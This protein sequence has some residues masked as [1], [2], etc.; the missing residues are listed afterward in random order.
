MTAYSTLILA[1]TPTAY[2]HLNETSGTTCT[3]SSGNSRTATH[4]TSPTL[5]QTSANAALDDNKCIL[6]SGAANERTQINTDN[7]A[8]SMK[9]GWTLELWVNVVTSANKYI[10][11]KDSVPNHYEWGLRWDH[12]N[13]RFVWQTVSPTYTELYTVYG[14]S[15]KSSGTWYHVAVTCNGAPGSTLPKLYVNGVQETS[16]GS[17][18]SGGTYTDDNSLVE[19]GARP[20]GAT[21]INAKIDE[22]A[23]FDSALTSTVLLSHY[24]AGLGIA[25]IS[26]TAV[27][28]DVSVAGQ[29]AVI[30]TVVI[31][32]T[33]SNIAV[34]GQAPT[35]AITSNPTVNAVSSNIAIAGRD[36]GSVGTGFEGIAVVADVAIQ[37][38]PPSSLRLDQ[39]FTAQKS[40]IAIGGIN[41]S[42]DVPQVGRPMF[43]AADH[44]PTWGTGGWSSLNEAVPEDVYYD[45]TFYPGGYS[46]AADR[47]ARFRITPLG[48]PLAG[49]R[50]ISYRWKHPGALMTF[51]VILQ[52]GET[53]IQ[54]WN[55]GSATQ[56]SYVTTTQTITGT[57]TDYTN[58]NVI[59]SASHTLAAAGDS[60]YV[61]YA[62][63]FLPTIATVLDIT[64]NA[65]RTDTTVVGAAP[66][67]ARGVEVGL[68]TDIGVEGFGP[69]IITPGGVSLSIQAAEVTVTGKDP[70]LAVFRDS[71]QIAIPTHI[72]LG[73]TASSIQ[74]QVD[75]FKFIPITDNNLTAADANELTAINLGP[76]LFS[77][78]KIIAF[79]MG[80]IGSFPIN[81]TITTMSVNETLTSL[82]TFSA[83]K[84]AYTSTII[85]EG[86]PP[87]GISDPIWMKMN[88]GSTL[89]GA[90]TIVID[91]EQSNA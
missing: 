41:P 60:M 69:A 66:A 33:V 61:S 77:Q 1:S 49:P 26:Q 8:F 46:P 65:L 74:T 4:I 73:F 39:I 68:P 15:G 13:T 20:I 85:V 70:T 22:V 89:P 10:I 5:N 72:D 11:N 81:L 2:Y 32:P 48:V 29:P 7:A 44:Y 67:V 58:L 23:F 82:A 53:E 36:P 28:T 9:S 76:L 62:A 55:H 31:T 34:A 64:V 80:N 75:S 87:N 38:I 17:S 37:S 63:I 71:V 54:R 57:I 52:Q 56:S 83:N 86:I 12:D 19:W 91:V 21:A 90:G 45:A 42:L 6:Y 35:L 84:V 43:N 50:T 30:S 47:R 79:K 14:T 3:D 18:G 78:E 59:F 88:A 40:N 16:A 27:V 24:N 25:N 51:Q